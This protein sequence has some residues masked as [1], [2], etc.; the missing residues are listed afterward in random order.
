NVQRQVVYEQRNRVLHGED[1]A[2][3]IREEWLPEV[4][5][6][7]VSDYTADEDNGEWELGDLVGAMDALYGTGV[8]VEELHG[9]DRE[10]VVQEF[11]DDALDAYAEREKEMNEIQEGLMRDLERFIVL[12]TVDT[13]WREHLEN[14]D[15]MREGI[16]LRGLAQK[17]PL[18][19]YRNEGHV[20]FQDLTRAIREEVVTLLFHAEITPDDG[21]G[22]FQQPQGANPNGSLTYEHESL[23][24]AEAIL[25][26]GGSSTYATGGGGGSVATPVAQKPKIN[27]ELE[28]VGRNDPCPCGSGKKYKKCHGA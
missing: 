26:A 3:D 4:I 17:D 23:A 27:S 6:N 15:Y 1:L 12:Q 5:S 22:G 8:T 21:S 13:R 10:A 11:I 14:M 24:G 20:M 7:V 28:S 2:E 16:G 9:L 25:A 18:V 19:E